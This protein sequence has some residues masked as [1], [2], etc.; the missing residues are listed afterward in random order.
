M[1]QEFSHWK[2]AGFGFRVK[3]SGGLSFLSTACRTHEHVFPS[4]RGAKGFS[5]VWP[6]SPPI[7]EHVRTTFLRTSH[8]MHGNKAESVFE[9]KRTDGTFDGIPALKPLT[10]SNKPNMKAL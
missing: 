5:S 9:I 7:Q 10:V 8:V 3:V 4:S 2:P 1:S 6:A